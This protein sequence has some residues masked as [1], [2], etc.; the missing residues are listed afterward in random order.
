MQRLQK[1]ATYYVTTL[2]QYIQL[3]CL[4]GFLREC[5]TQIQFH[6]NYSTFAEFR[7]CYTLAWALVNTLIAHTPAHKIR[8]SACFCHIASTEA[9]AV[10]YFG[11]RRLLNRN[12][13]Y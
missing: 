9:K 7:S 1:K 8:S 4:F 6:M 5:I 2:E 3:C 13:L 12:S 11:R 10:Q